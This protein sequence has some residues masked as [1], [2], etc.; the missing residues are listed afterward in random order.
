MGL[1]LA[2][3]L[4]AAL[5]LLW[6]LSLGPISLDLLTP[7]IEEA[8]NLPG[9][10]LTIR[11]DRTVLAAGA[12]GRLVEIN[13]L[14]VRALGPDGAIVAQVPVMAL[15]LSGR[16][17]LHG[18]LAPHS[19]R[20]VGPRLA[21]SRDRAGALHWGIGGADTGAGGTNDT[22]SASPDSAAVVAALREALLG[23]P[24]PDRPGRALQSFAIDDAVVTLD[25]Q[26]LGGRISVQHAA[27]V[28]RRVADGLVA[29]AHLPLDLDGATATLG[30]EASYH[31]PDGVAEAMVRLGSVRP[32]VL[33]RLAPPFAMLAGL[34]FAVSGT[35]R[36]SILP[37]GALGALSADLEAG[38]GEVT[39]PPPLNGTRH[40]ERAT[41]RAAL[42]GGLTR[43][44]VS[45]F[46]LDFGGPV[47]RGHAVLDGLGADLTADVQA[48]VRD[49][50][51]DRLRDLWPATLAVNA[52]TWVVS[53]LSHGMVREATMALSARA[54]SGRIDDLAIDHMGGRIRAEGV[55]V[56]YLHPMPAA[57]QVSAEC[58]FDAAA[59]RI[60]LKGGELYGLRL[61]EG[62]VVLGGLDKV[63][64]DADIDVTVAGPLPD[65]LRLI[66]SPPLRY[67]QALGIDS[68]RVGGEAVTRL[69]LKFPLLQA[70]RLDDIAVNAHTSLR[71]L[72]LPKVV[73]GQDLE[74][75]Q[76]DLDV[77]G[78][79]LDAAGA[80]LLGRI[81]A[82]LRWRENFSA[83]GT[84]F[85]SRYQLRAP[86]VSEE[87]RRQLGLDGPPF[88]APLLA[89]PVGA[90]VTATFFEAGRGEIAATLDLAPARMEISGLGWSKPAGT[91][92]TA[93]VRVALDHQSIRSVP[94]FAVRAGD[95]DTVGSVA[96]GPDGRARRVE[97]SSVAIGRT[98]GEA[99]LG[100]RSDG[101]FD[102]TFHGPSFDAAPV[103]DAK[104][105][106]N[107][108]KP[109][110]TVAATVGKLWV[111]K[112]GALSDVSLRMRRDGPDWRTIT[113]DGGLDGGKKLHLAL[114]PDSSGRRALTLTSK[115][116]GAVMRTFGFYED[117][118]GGD[119]TVEG[120]Y[121]EARPGKP[122]SGVIRVSDYYL[123][124]APALARLLTVAALTGVVDLLRGQGVG[125]SSLEAPFSLT[126]G[127]L[128]VRDARAWGAAL[129]IT[130]K[131]QIDLD[132]GRLAIEGT[133]V[134]AYA[135][136]SVLGRIPVLGW[137]VTGGE[138]G[139]GVIAF[140]YTMKGPTDDPSVTVNP[141]SALTPGFLRNLFNLF[142]DGSGTR[143]RTEPSP[144]K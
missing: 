35:V 52:R 43:A 23:D 134:P 142:D 112:A 113:L 72:M 109:P 49:V 33:A 89:G 57:R 40:I 140:N 99:G 85:R 79:G 115:D 58:T 126:D 111:S 38:A 131:G 141:L 138:A 119:L 48:S 71:N 123:H 51:V 22:P 29:S 16:A 136:N 41:V 53:S 90:D 86:A 84:A 77:D 110:M 133:V 4:V 88:V 97:L 83:K 121:D 73:L 143:A 47:L 118:V 28:I 124:D 91:A 82:H 15:S 74:S 46:S 65:A 135:L 55:S 2:G 98:R 96:F 3:L 128:E 129:G 19:M 106:P 107:E 93:E 18:V 94:R 101:G 81:P 76:L 102:V 75:P 116:A 125:F 80:V 44:E 8:L 27:L 50:P 64:Q 31:K 100:L 34:D 37:S 59:M 105:A 137:L 66:D 32:S 70:L 87:Q 7:S 12:G 108:D 78:K 122:L 132:G 117:L 130:A 20:L 127:L 67:A 45:E 24:Q 1:A 62:V 61:K 36:A 103:L 63:D 144:A 54:A 104:S 69:R 39:L 120:R 56:D 25:D 11:L 17:L 68:S 9:Q 30:I 114:A 60:A 139:G 95:L 13:A 42:V 21:L 10:A 92:G 5:V 26:A 6:R 14:N